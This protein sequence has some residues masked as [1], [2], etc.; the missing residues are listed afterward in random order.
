[1]MTSDAT[2]AAVLRQLHNTAVDTCWQWNNWKNTMAGQM[3]NLTAA[4]A[5]AV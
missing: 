2:A 4:A 1:M 3:M 5:A